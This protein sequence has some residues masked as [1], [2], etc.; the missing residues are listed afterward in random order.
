MILMV[1]VFRKKERKRREFTHRIFLD[2]S[3]YILQM[4]LTSL[5]RSRPALMPGG[6]SSIVDTGS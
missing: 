5:H 3:E 6:T 2:E 4:M 1:I